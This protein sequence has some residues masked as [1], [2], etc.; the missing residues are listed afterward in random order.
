MSRQFPHLG[1]GEAGFD[2]GAMHGMLAGRRHSRAVIAAVVEV[3]PVDE[4]VEFESQVADSARRGPIEQLLEPRV[5]LGLAEI[6]AVRGVLEVIG[7]LEFAAFRSRDAE[8]RSGRRA[9]RPPPARPRRDS[10]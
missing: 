3:G 7:V 10:R 8:C 1:L 4:D 9:S 5:Q 6:A 2:Q